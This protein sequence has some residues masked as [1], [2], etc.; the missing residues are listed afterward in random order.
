L[1]DLIRLRESLGAALVVVPLLVGCGG[2]ASPAGGGGLVGNTP[3]D[4]GQLAPPDDEPL[5]SNPALCSSGA[6]CGTRQTIG[7]AIEAQLESCPRTFQ[8]RT[9]YFSFDDQAT[10]GR[11]AQAQDVCCY[12][13]QAECAEGTL[14]RPHRDGAH[15]I[16]AGAR[17]VPRQLSPEAA[18][19]LGDALAEHASIDRGVAAAPPPAFARAT[20]EL[21][22]VGAPTELVAGC[23]RAALDELRHA[24]V[25]LAQASRLAGAKLSFGA[26]PALPPRAPSLR[27]LA[28]DTFAE[29]CV[30]ETI[31]AL[32][33]VRRLAAERDPSVRRLLRM[34]ARDEERHA[35]PKDAWTG[36]VQPLIDSLREG[37]RARLRPSA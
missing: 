33:A 9:T 6:W 7:T 15:A 19:W 14:G 32:E 21:L 8:H 10:A 29:G 5:P 22:A 17:G 26:L 20:Q 37:T 34:I 23:H 24:R 3:A 31:G 35:A 30:G 1:R 16:V 4:G 36:V 2:K 12:T 27:R 25:T 13:W 11:T 18:R 28:A